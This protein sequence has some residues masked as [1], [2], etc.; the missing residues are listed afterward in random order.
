VFII[1]FYFVFIPKKYKQPDVIFLSAVFALA[2]TSLNEKSATFFT[3]VALLDDGCSPL[4]EF[5]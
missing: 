2:G 5:Y 3:Q 1:C 4:S